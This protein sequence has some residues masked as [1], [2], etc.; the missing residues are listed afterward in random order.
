[1]EAGELLDLRLG[2]FASPVT[3]AKSNSKRLSIISIGGEVILPSLLLI[4]VSGG[5]QGAPRLPN[6]LEAYTE[7]AS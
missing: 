3:N 7:E 1:M 2:R 6:L 4:C 5:Q